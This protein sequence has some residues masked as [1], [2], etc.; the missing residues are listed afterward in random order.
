MSGQAGKSLGQRAYE[1]NAALLAIGEQ[2][3]KGGKPQMGPDPWHRLTPRI[4]HHWET[5]AREFVREVTQTNEKAIIERYEKKK[6]ALEAER[7]AKAMREDLF[8][9]EV[10]RRVAEALAE[11]RKT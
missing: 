7:E 4:R 3:G 9:Q 1:R 10:R 11:S 2:I 8:E 5:F 6:H